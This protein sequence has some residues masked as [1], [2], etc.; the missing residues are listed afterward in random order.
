MTLFSDIL[1]TAIEMGI[2][3]SLESSETSRK[4]NSLSIL[5]WSLLGI[6]IVGMTGF[7]IALAPKLAVILISTV[8]ISKYCYRTSLKRIVLCFIVYLLA[9]SIGEVMCFGILRIFFGNAVSVLMQD[10]VTLLL[11][12]VISKTLTLLFLTSVKHLLKKIYKSLGKALFLTVTPLFACFL[13]LCTESFRIYSMKELTMQE[14]LYTGMNIVFMVISAFCTVRLIEKYLQTREVEAQ[15]SLDIEQISDS[16]H[17]L[18]KKAESGQ[19]VAELYHD[20]K[21]HLLILKAKEEHSGYIDGLL[22]KINDFEAF[23]DTGNPI[24]NTLIYEKHKLS[25]FHEIRMESSINLNCHTP[26]KD[27]DICAIFGNAIDNAVEAC[28][29]IDNPENRYI[30]ISA[31]KIRRFL[32]IKIENSRQ[33]EEFHANTE[34]KSSKS[35]VSLHGYGL[36]SIRRCVHKYNGEM[37]VFLGRTTFTLR[38]AIPLPDTT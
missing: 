8:C 12:I 36:K 38:I 37:A 1:G 29:K 23:I 11:I 22:H 26:L 30:K 28:L 5:L 3:Y 32:I 33:K 15:T 25:Q 16:Y 17:Y 19:Q 31:G 14:C 13:V 2:L 24:L 18:A 10:P 21:N 7:Q 34:L 9:I 4:K 27:F 20:L 6:L 35:D